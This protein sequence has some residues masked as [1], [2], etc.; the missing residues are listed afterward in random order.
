MGQNF[1]Y[2]IISHPQTA[3]EPGRTQESEL[4]RVT[5]AMKTVSGD[6]VD[7]A[8]RHVDEPFDRAAVETPRDAR[9]CERRSAR[10]RLIRILG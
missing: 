10:L 4:L 8:T 7:D 6:D 3:W 2:K 1:Y 9:Q 5:R